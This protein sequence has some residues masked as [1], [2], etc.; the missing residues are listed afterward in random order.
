MGFKGHH[1]VTMFEFVFKIFE[2]SLLYK[3]KGGFMSREYTLG[4]V[5]RLTGIPYYRIYYGHYTGQLGEPKR[6]GRIRVYTD[7]DVQ[8]IKNVLGRH[9]YTAD[10]RAAGE[11]RKKK[12]AG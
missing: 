8:N 12:G 9:K 5:A 11:A 6:V 1:N 7:E 10:Q 2:G 4:E 3:R